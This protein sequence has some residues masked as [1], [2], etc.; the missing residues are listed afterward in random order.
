[1][2][3]NGQF[4]ADFNGTDFETNNENSGTKYCGL[5]KFYTIFGTTTYWRSGIR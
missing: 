1:M 4:S 5:D 2:I 3:W